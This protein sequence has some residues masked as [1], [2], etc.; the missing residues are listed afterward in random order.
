MESNHRHERPV[1]LSRRA[2]PR[3]RIVFH[4]AVFDTENRG[5]TRG[6]ITLTDA[7][8][9]RK[10]EESN[11]RALPRRRVQTGFVTLT[12]PSERDYIP[13]VHVAARPVGIEP[14]QA[15]FGISPPPSGV[16]I[17]RVYL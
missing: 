10:V 4:E 1:P 16:R 6:P 17:A 12:L 2:R 9:W 15:R 14:T 7:Q 11:P 3:G 13:E 8:A 5:E